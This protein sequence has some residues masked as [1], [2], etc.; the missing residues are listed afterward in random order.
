MLVD[1]ELDADS[2]GVNDSE[3]LHRFRTDPT[4]PDTHGDGL[5]DHKEFVMG[6]DPC[7]NASP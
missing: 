6:T 2:D 1:P 5:S 7:S 3:E 4:N